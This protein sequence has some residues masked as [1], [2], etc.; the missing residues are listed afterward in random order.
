MLPSKMYLKMFQRPQ[1]PTHMLNIH[2]Q[3]FKCINV[4]YIQKEGTAN[5]TG[6]T[7]SR[8]SANGLAR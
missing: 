2:R 4:P 5:H 6:N 3:Y 8:K 7:I 1:E